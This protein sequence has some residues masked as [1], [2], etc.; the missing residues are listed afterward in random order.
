M[1]L[2]QVAST[3]NETVIAVSCV[4]A[5]L[6]VPAVS[7]FWPWWRSHFGRAFMLLDAALALVLAGEV[8]RRFLGADDTRVLFIW[9]DTVLRL[10]AVPAVLYCGISLW[11][12]QRNPARTL[13]EARDQVRSRYVPTGSGG[14]EE[15]GDAVRP[16]PHEDSAENIR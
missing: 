4:I 14:D 7:V 8:V 9:L 10:L 11:R 2:I 15:R 1:N 5:V 16:E 13:R 6:F 3:V 12:I